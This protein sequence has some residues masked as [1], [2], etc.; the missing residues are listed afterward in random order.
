MAVNQYEYDYLFDWAIPD[1]KQQI[2]DKST[3]N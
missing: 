3:P 2:T 1:K